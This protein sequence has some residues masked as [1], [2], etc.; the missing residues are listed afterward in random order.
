[1]IYSKEDVTEP[2]WAEFSAQASGRDPLAI[3]NSSVVIYTKMMVGITNVTNRIRY[4]GFYCWLLEIILKRSDVKGSVIEQLRYLRR[5]ELLLAYMMVKEFSDVTGVSG[6]AYAKKHFNEHINLRNGADWDAKTESNEIYWKFKGGIFGQYYSG[7]VRELGLIN[8][9][10]A[11]LNIYTVTPE[12]EK[13]ADFFALN[14]TATKA[15]LFWESIKSGHIKETILTEL[16]SF[17]LHLIPESDEMEFYKKI[18][19]SHDDRK[20]EPTF[21]RQQTII[22]L[23]KY[24]SFQKD[25]TDYLPYLFLKENYKAHISLK[26]LPNDAATAWYIYEINELLHVT[27]EHFHACLLWSIET[28]PLSLDERINWLIQQTEIAFEEMNIEAKEYSLDNFMDS[29][30][31]NDSR[32]YEHFSETSSAFNN[33]DFGACLKNSI[34]TL[35]SI[36]YDC[37]HQLP[38]VRE[39]ACLPEYNFNRPGYVIELI[40]ELIETKLNFTISKYTRNI[41]LMA[42]NLHVFSSY[43]KTKVG[44]ALVHNYMIEDD[45]I[46]RLRETFPNRTTPRLQNAIQYLTDVGWIKKDGKLIFITDSGTQLL[47]E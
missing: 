21:Y 15:D 34:F 9:P 33:G 5:A 24:L 7:V 45:L 13:L 11:E 25:G 26:T 30:D 14:I 8:H 43:T 20:V 39:F 19:L 27:L 16:S 28:Y 37:K 1:M 22:Q 46:W 4:N 38:Q 18:L 40:T 41:L 6:S 2:F 23:L 3:Q 31:A 36:Y 47:A 12:G 44:Q 10:N 42:I 17:A 29:F 32:T 35:L